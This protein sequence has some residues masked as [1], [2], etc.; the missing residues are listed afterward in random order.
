MRWKGEVQC[1]RTPFPSILHT[2][3]KISKGGDADIERIIGIGWRG[4]KEARRWVLADGL[5]LLAAWPHVEVQGLVV[6][7]K[8]RF[9]L[10]LFTS[11]THSKSIRGK[12]KKPNG[13]LDTRTATGSRKQ[14]SNPTSG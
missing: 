14:A 4:R 12:T 10:V 7:T 2:Q 6:R 9:S 11:V 3:R 13:A 5:Q 8:L 1:G